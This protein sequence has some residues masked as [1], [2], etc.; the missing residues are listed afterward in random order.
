MPAAAMDMYDVGAS[1]QSSRKSLSKA[2]TGNGGRNDVSNPVA[3]MMASTSRMVPLAMQRPDRFT[4]RI[5]SLTTL[6]FFDARA[7]R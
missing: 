3:Q 7:S 2:S 6:T 5:A 1:F 4:A